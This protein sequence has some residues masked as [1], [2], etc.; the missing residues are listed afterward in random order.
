MADEKRRVMGELAAW[1][2]AYLMRAHGEN[3]DPHQI[4]PYRMVTVEEVEARARLKQ[5]RFF[6]AMS[7]GLFGRNVTN[8]PLPPTGEQ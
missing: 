4:N 1:Q 3:L 5:R 8:D 2:V 7:V 6:S